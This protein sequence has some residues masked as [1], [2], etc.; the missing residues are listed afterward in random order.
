MKF[1]KTLI[2]DDLVLPILLILIYGVFLYILKGVFPNSEELLNTFSKIYGRFGYEI[3]FFASLFESL[4]L[5]NALVPGGLALSLGVILTKTGEN[6]LFFIILA[7]AIAAIFGYSIDY[8]L[9]YFGFSKVLQ[10]TKYTRFIAQANSKIGQYGTRG[11]ILGFIHPNIGS[12]VSLT[13]GTLGFKFKKFI[14]IAIISTIFWSSIWG[15]VIYLLGDQV[16]N[17]FRK[18]GYLMVLIYILGIVLLRFW[19]EKGE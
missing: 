19:K 7:G 2:A 12:V 16:L 4:V 17:L 9:G 15:V 18:Y 5:V 8:F 10:K 14:T 11:L 3:V 1:I 6:L 13:A